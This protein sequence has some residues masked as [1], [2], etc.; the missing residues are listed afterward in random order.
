MAANAKQR[1][2]RVSEST[3]SILRD[4]AEESGD[5]MTVV[6]DRAVELYRREQLFALAAAQWQA[7]QGDPEARAELA[8]EY[9]IWETTVA[10]GLERE[11]W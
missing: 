6:L 3:H 11:T 1:H 9:A 4:L 7:I 5:P 8:A 10:D 2:V